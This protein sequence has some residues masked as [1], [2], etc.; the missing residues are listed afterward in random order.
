MTDHK[1]IE[2]IRTERDERALDALYKHFPLMQKM[3]RFKGGTRNDAED[4]FQEA[5]IIFVKAARKSDFT[6]TE[7]LSSY[8]FSVCRYLW[9]D[10]LIKRQRYIPLDWDSK[11]T[12]AEEEQ[13]HVALEEEGREKLAEKALDGLKERCRELLLIFYQGRLTLKEIALKM[14]YSSENVAKNQ[15]YKCLEAARD[16]LKELQQITQTS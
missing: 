8:L 12:T 4:V 6:L 13:L 11:L 14:G 1:I 15:K 3:I 16:R 5:L 10:E 9:K 7:K 2:L